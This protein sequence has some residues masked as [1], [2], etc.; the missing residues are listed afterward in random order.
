MT[1]KN[2][3]FLEVEKRN[4]KNPDIRLSYYIYQRNEAGQSCS[5][6]HYASG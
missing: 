1:K 5:S 6:Y 3:L 2:K 4:P